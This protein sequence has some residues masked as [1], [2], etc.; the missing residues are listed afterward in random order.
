[1][2][3]DPQRLHELS[4]L[5][6]ACG[7]CCS[8]AMFAYVPL[9][10]DE[11]SEP[12]RVRLNVFN[13]AGEDRF[14][15]PCAALEAQ[16]CGVYQ[17]RPSVCRSYKCAVYKKHES[18]GD[19]FEGKLR[20]VRRVRALIDS[21]RAHADASKGDWLPPVIAEMAEWDTEKIRSLRAHV[22]EEVLLDIAELG[23]RV[24]RDMLEPKDK[25]K[26]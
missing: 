12:T 22:G 2:T 13:V 21:I 23:M 26:G 6:R 17:D 3:A 1:M 5:C 11:P 8:G 18:E 24:R 19:D 25:D 7:A 20:N 15:L 16:G 10:P 14:K 9:D 4:T